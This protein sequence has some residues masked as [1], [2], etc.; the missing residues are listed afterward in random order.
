MQHGTHVATRIGSTW[1]TELGPDLYFE[2]VLQLTWLGSKYSIEPGLI[3]HVES[4]VYFA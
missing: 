2:P 4:V 1:Q 3:L